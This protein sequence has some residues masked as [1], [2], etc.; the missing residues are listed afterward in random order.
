MRD[1]DCINIGTKIRL[2]IKPIRLAKE[3]EGGKKKNRWKTKLRL[4]ISDK[5]P[6]PCH[7][8][9]PLP[10]NIYYTFTFWRNVPGVSPH[11]TETLPIS[12]THFR[13]FS[14]TIGSVSSVLMTSTTFMSY[15]VVLV[16]NKTTRYQQ[17]SNS[18]TQLSS[19][20]L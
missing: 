9:I 1:I 8:F 6:I 14:R 19:R 10:R 2:T 18:P 15:Y 12:S 16:R 3:I 13:P 20:F 4:E 7:S 17:I 11:S 5:I